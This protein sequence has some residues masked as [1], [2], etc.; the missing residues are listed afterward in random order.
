MSYVINSNLLDEPNPTFTGESIPFH[1]SV[2]MS[3]LRPAACV[4]LMCEK[5]ANGGEYMDPGVMAACN[6]NPYTT[7]NNHYAN[8]S[9]GA[10]VGYTNGVGQL[11]ANWKRFAAR[12]NG[13]GNL[14]FAD[15]HVSYYKWAQVQ[16]FIND[17]YQQGN[18]KKLK[19][20]DETMP[21]TNN[22][23]AY[24]GLNDNANSPTIIWDPFGP[25]N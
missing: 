19:Y 22:A 13:G 23:K 16:L 20:T 9:T 10:Y 12:H 24:S 21:G 14:L 4:V 8:G 18:E 6:A 3:Q 2:R 5:L 25:C 15:G 1:Y 7:G 17:N 11:K